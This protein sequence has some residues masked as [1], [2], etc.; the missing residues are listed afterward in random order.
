PGPGR[1][2]R[3]AG[4]GGRLRPGGR[5]GGRGR[6]VRCPGRG[7]Q[8][9]VLERAAAADQMAGR[10]VGRRRRPGRRRRGGG[11]GRVARAVL[12][13]DAPE[14]YFP[15]RVAATYDDDPD[16]FGPGTVDAVVGVLAE[17]AGRA[18]SPGHG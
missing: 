5:L 4:P 8:R 6:P 2:G 14:D 1:P 11:P 3:P 18:A 10:R 7:G 16:I 9:G 12:T 17:L 13:V 15:E